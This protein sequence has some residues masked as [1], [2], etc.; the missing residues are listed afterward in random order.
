MDGRYADAFVNEGRTQREVLEIW[1]QFDHKN[2]QRNLPP[3]W[4]LMI[5]FYRASAKW[6]K[7]WRASIDEG[8]A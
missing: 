5:V 6:C 7:L 4:L 8:W 1:D 3:Q 2:V